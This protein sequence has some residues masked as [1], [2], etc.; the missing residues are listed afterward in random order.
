MSGTWTEE[1]IGSQ[2]YGSGIFGNSYY[3]SVT[4]IDET[5]ASATWSGSSTPSTT[6]TNLSDA[7]LT[8]ADTSA[9]RLE[10]EGTTSSQ[11]NGG[12][13]GSGNAADFAICFGMVG[14]GFSVDQKII[15]TN[16]PYGQPGMGNIAPIDPYYD[17]PGGVVD[18]TTYYVQVGFETLNHGPDGLANN[19]C[20][21]ATPG[22][23]KIQWTT[24]W[25]GAFTAGDLH[26]TLYGVNHTVHS[27]HP[28]L[29]APTIATWTK[30]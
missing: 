27:V 21:S 10:H 28:G 17:L 25:Q 26:P 13:P 24:G 1:P 18:G 20:V 3:G 11:E 14:H 16:N 23:S 6:W 7:S 2:A 30:V 4:W 12:P 15:F 8:W 29:T 19:F 5:L 9:D 22:G